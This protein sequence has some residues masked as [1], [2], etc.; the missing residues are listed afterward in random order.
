[1]SNGAYYP[2]KFLTAG[3]KVEEGTTAGVYLRWFVQPY[4]G[5][6]G[7]SPLNSEK[8]VVR[9]EVGFRLFYHVESGQDRPPL[10]PIPLDP[11]L[12]KEPDVVID[13]VHDLPNWKATYHPAGDRNIVKLD[14]HA[15]YKFDIC[16]LRFQ[17]TRS[18]RNTPYACSTPFTRQPAA[19]NAA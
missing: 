15:K 13:D 4:L 8:I 7:V 14:L 6:P 16:Y 2:V 19:N 9:K 11:I 1:M 12:P 3:N 18:S 17:A 5:V 10:Q